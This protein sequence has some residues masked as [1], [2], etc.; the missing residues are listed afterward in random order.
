LWPVAAV[1]SGWLLCDGSAVSRTTYSSLYALFTPGGIN[2]IYGTGDGS[3]TF[4]LPNLKGRVPVGLDPTQVEFDAL[5]EIGGAKTHTLTVAQMPAHTH[6]DTNYDAL[7]IGPG[8]QSG[9]N[10]SVVSLSAATGTS[11]GGSAHNN[12][13]PYL[14]LNYI[15]KV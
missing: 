8:I 14:T 10:V 11:G 13:A 12:L 1:P 9:S 2:A 3:T 4:N 7:G 6:S 5:G 15:I